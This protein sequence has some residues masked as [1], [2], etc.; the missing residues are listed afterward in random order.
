MLHFVDKFGQQVF[1]AYKIPS[2]L[3]RLNVALILTMSPLHV[4]AQ[5]LGEAQD[6]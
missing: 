1:V 3:A 4:S 2:D 6:N 5:L